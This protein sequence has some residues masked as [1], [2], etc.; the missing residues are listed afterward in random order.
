MT[1][2]ELKIKDVE[3]RINETIEFAANDYKTNGASVWGDQQRHRIYGMIE[4][5]KI[6]T[7]K[8][9]YFDANGLHERKA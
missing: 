4:V 8:D 7:G 5:L 3:H 9:Y 2:L 1:D 6:L